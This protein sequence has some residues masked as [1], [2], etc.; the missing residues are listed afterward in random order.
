MINIS[1]EN[2]TIISIENKSPTKPEEKNKCIFVRLYSPKYKNFDIGSSFLQFGQNVTA[3]KNWKI[4]S[5]HAAIA[6]NLKDKFYGLSIFNGDAHL[7]PESCKGYSKGYISAKDFDLEKS[8][9]TVIGFK[10][11]D[12]EYNIAKR[13][14]SNAYYGKTVKFDPMFAGLN[15][16]F[17]S[18]CRKIKQAFSKSNKS[19]ED[20]GDLSKSD[21]TVSKEDIDTVK[22]V[23]STFVASVLFTSIKSLREHFEKKENKKAGKYVSPSDIANFPGAKILFSGKFNTY[24]K[25]AEKFVAEHPEFKIYLQ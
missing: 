7:K 20:L 4:T 15:M 6:L 21:V 11:T 1:L 24:G 2:G 17:Y 14:I 23:C 10:C 25:D 18:I 22:K 12:K 16:T 13:E 9:Y 8:E 5:A 19:K 3:D